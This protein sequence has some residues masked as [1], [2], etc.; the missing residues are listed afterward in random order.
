[1][2]K[3][4]IIGIAGGT[5]SGK[6]TIADAIVS[7]FKDQVLSIPHDRYY[8]S[9]DALSM[10]ERVKT[11]YDHPQALETDLLI[12]HIHELL[13]GQ[14]VE[15][16]DYDFSIHTRKKETTSEKPAP[17]ILIEG[18]LIYE[19]KALRELIDLKIFVDVPAD[20]RILRRIRR[21]VD[22]RGRTVE[23]SMKQYFTTIRPMH[24][25]FVEP[26][27]QYADILIP[28]GGHNEK[29]IQAMIDTIEQRLK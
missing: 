25:F 11:N 9:Q 18:I 19:N 1:M 24:E 8:R 7:H 20:I 2:N 26:S 17:L 6:T 15:M 29:G 5:G 12:Q 23:M 13:I 14:T 3:P 27:K 10:E 21:D 28:H 22:E 16:P 4:Y